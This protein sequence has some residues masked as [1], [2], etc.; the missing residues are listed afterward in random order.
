MA[1]TRPLDYIDVAARLMDM[2]EKFPDLTMQQVK[3][4]FVQIAG[5]D[6]V[7]YTA[8]AYRTP[9]DQRPGIGTAWEPIPGPTP[10]TKDS[11]VQNAET[12]A[13]GR[14]LVAIGASTKNGIASAEEVTNRTGGQPQEPGEYRNNERVVPNSPPRQPSD[15][16]LRNPG[17][18]YVHGSGNTDFDIILQAATL[19][20]NDFM[21]SLAKQIEEKGTLTDKQISSGVPQAFKIVNGEG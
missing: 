7:V 1:F 5:K 8:A 2:R 12:A 10:Y 21:H 3:M 17:K 13:W 18:G 14:A 19:S 9:D 6:W 15:T 11:E 20:D 4:E 16:P